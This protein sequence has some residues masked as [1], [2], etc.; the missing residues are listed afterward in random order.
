[1]GKKIRS[2]VAE[3]TSLIPNIA[4]ALEEA[5]EEGLQEMHKAV[6]NK[7][8]S[9]TEYKQ[10][11]IDGNGKGYAVVI[12]NKGEITLKGTFTS[13]KINGRTIRVPGEVLEAV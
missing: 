9:Y 5:L 4:P 3:V 7:K 12:S 1:M 11:G 10:F 2:L 6:G 8:L 13:L